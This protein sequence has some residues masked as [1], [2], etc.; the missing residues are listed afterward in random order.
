[1]KKMALFTVALGVGLLMSIQAHATNLS[2]D[3]RYGDGQDRKAFDQ[4]TDPMSVPEPSSLLMLASGLF[5][6]GGAGFVSRRKAN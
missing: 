2:G 6:L 5:A 1:V 3:G 4:T